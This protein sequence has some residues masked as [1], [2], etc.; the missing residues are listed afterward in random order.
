MTDV[1]AVFA[2]LRATTP[3]AYGRAYRTF[4]GPED[5]NI[6]AYVDGISR[7]PGIAFKVPANLWIDGWE[8]PSMKGVQIVARRHEETQSVPSEVDFELRAADE[9]FSVVFIELASRLIVDATHELTGEASLRAIESRVSL[10]LRFFN[11]RGSAALSRSAQLGLIGELLCFLRLL[12]FL[13]V[14][15][16]VSSWT[17]PQGTTHDFQNAR[18]AVEVKLTT[19]SSPERVRI[20]SERQLDESV[21]PWLSLFVV[22]AQEVAAG[23]TG[24][25]SLVD[26]VRREVRSASQTALTSLEERLLTAGYLDGDRDAYD[27]RLTIRSIDFFRVSGDFP[28]IRPS[29]IR[30][31]VFDVAYTIPWASIEPYRISDTQVQE[32]LSVAKH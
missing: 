16:C 13:G 4:G 14:Y 23:T 32:A 9:S 12:K 24:L 20:T 25:P 31:G 27:V 10:W 7:L 29:E 8:L 28:R 19:S 17:G 11:A 5:L 3:H 1:E 15:E 2:E 30:T 26:E 21:I 22:R 18:G 6:R